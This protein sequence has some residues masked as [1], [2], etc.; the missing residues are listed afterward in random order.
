[1]K[2]INK[3]NHFR[4]NQTVTD[5]KIEIN[6]NNRRR[7]ITASLYNSIDPNISAGATA[8]A[9]G[10]RKRMKTPIKSPSCL[11]RS[12]LGKS[13]NIGN[14]GPLFS[15]LTM[16]RDITGEDLG[17]KTKNI[18]KWAETIDNDMFLHVD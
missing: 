14:A 17:I 13:W 9:I 5:L 8:V 10:Y 11:T 7:N 12:S 6:P 18:K 2:Y 4:Y 1:M 3:M 16:S 15:N